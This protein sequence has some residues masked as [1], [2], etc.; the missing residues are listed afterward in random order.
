[1]LVFNSL[2]I[3]KSPN[4]KGGDFVAYV[5]DVKVK[6]E[7][8]FTRDIK[9]IDNE[10]VWGIHKATDAKKQKHEDLMRWLKYSGSNQEEEYLKEEQNRQQTK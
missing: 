8:Y 10:A 6:Y 7:P 3:Y 5:K 4:E 1:M 2:V 9:D